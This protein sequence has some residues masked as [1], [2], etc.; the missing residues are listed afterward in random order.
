MNLVDAHIVSPEHLSGGPERMVVL[1]P[2]GRVAIMINEEDHLRIQVVLSGLAPEEAW[3]AVDDVDEE[4][5]RSLQF[6]YSERYGYLTASITNLGTGL[7]I[8]ALMHLGGLAMLGKLKTTLKAAHELGVS[9]RGLFGEGTAGFGDFFQVSNEVTLGLEEQEIVG[10]VRGVARHLLEE[11]YRA[12]ELLAEEQS[13]RLVATAA[14]CIRAISR[15]QALSAQEALRLLSPIRVACSAGFS[16][17]PR[18]KSS[19]RTIRR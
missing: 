18:W 2:S 9:V 14:N 5:A 1:E 15:A 17:Q 13:A 8:S 19:A 7:R 4:L 12:R 11:E 3:R 6:A 16:E 10:R